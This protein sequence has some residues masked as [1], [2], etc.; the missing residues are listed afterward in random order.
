MKSTLILVDSNLYLRIRI[1][2]RDLVIAAY[3]Q[4]KQHSLSCPVEHD[5]NTTCECQNH[6][7]S[8]IYSFFIHT[9]RSTWKYHLSLEL[10]L[11]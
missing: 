9:K 10:H 3:S 4:M 6:F 8:L 11:C 1:N 2:K 5:M 7:V